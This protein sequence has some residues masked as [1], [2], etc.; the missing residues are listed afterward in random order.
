MQQW[1][2]RATLLI[3]LAVLCCGR[4]IDTEG[5]SLDAVEKVWR[6]VNDQGLVSILDDDSEVQAILR[7]SLA[8][9]AFERKLLCPGR[10][11]ADEDLKP[12][13]CSVATKDLS[14]HPPVATLKFR[15][16]GVPVETESIDEQVIRIDPSPCQGPSQA[17]VV[18]HYDRIAADS[19]TVKDTAVAIATG[20]HERC[21]DVQQEL[22]DVKKIHAAQTRVVEGLFV[23]AL[24]ELESG[25]LHIFEVLFNTSGEASEL[26]LP[27]SLHC[28]ELWRSTQSWETVKLLSDP[29]LT[30][31]GGGSL[32]QRISSTGGHISA[33]DALVPM[34][35]APEL[36]SLLQRSKDVALSNR[37]DY[38]PGQVYPKCFPSSIVTNQG[39]CGSCWAMAAVGAVGD[40]H[41][42]ANPSSMLEP[43]T[44]WRYT[45]S[46]QQVLSCHRVNGCAGGHAHWVYGPMQSGQLKLTYTK[47]YPYASRCF[48]TEGGVTQDWGSYSCYVFARLSDDN[49]Q[50]PCGCVDSSRRLVEQP[51]C[52]HDVVEGLGR[53]R[54]R[55][56]GRLPKPGQWKNLFQPENIWTNSEVVQLI[57]STLFQEGPVYASFDVY[58]D[59]GHF[60]RMTRGRSVYRHTSRS[61]D[62]EGGHAVV[63]VGWGSVDGAEYWSMR[64]S[65]GQDWGDKGHY[66][67]IRGINDCGVESDIVVPKVLKEN[68][69]HT[70]RLNNFSVKSFMKDDYLGFVRRPIWVLDVQCSN[71]CKPMFAVLPDIKVDNLSTWGGSKCCCDNFNY[72]RETQCAWVPKSQLAEGDW[73]KLTF[74]KQACGRYDLGRGAAQ[75][76]EGTASLCSSSLEHEATDGMQLKAENL[77]ST[78]IRVSIDL[79]LQ[80]Q[81]RGQSHELLLKAK[82]PGTD[83]VSQQ[84][85]SVVPKYS[86]NG[87]DHAARK[88]FKF[89][90]LSCDWDLVSEPIQ[91]KT[92]WGREWTTRSYY[93]LRI[94]AS[95][96]E[97]CHG[98]AIFEGLRDRSLHHPN[99][100]ALLSANEQ[101]S[102]DPR[103]K[104]WTAPLEE[105]PPGKTSLRVEVWPAGRQSKAKKSRTKTIE[106]PRAPGVSNQGSLWNP[107]ELSSGESELK[108]QTGG[109]FGM[110]VDNVQILRVA[111]SRPCQL[112]KF[113]FISDHPGWPVQRL[114]PPE[115][116]RIAVSITVGQDGGWSEA[117]AKATIDVKDEH[118]SVITRNVGFYL[119]K[120]GAIEI[121]QE[122]YRMD[123]MEA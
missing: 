28:E 36:Q 107:F 122:Q 80:P 73:L 39:S 114:N 62:K 115:R 103:V 97:D 12:D 47:R 22:T 106:F 78:R 74:G 88:L 26:V 86:A 34:H 11:V 19:K 17:E 59:F 6:K 52:K 94:T 49:P 5:Q 48:V 64:N 84:L 30:D 2:R 66:K 25:A 44:D 90:S 105:Y 95:C 91:V 81:L 9:I 119:A 27:S 87:K 123:G 113:R 63:M 43:G 69:Y 116:D 23:R 57:Q 110:R 33:L 72:Q 99:G 46:V 58:Q 93:V 92:L 3:L 70:L 98:A 50:K 38:H 35:S 8:A 89:D 54:I 42:I 7:A 109:F 117:W 24:T 4:R 71:P 76:E 101:P 14:S 82:I 51:E 53:F 83:I 102:E 111:C 65:W 1:L 85:Y 112:Q 68:V 118:N 31:P 41:C 121:G 55:S 18:D 61:G 40:R 56:Y 104:K 67:H 32:L 10:S 100:T 108:Q 45:L 96:S 60:V 15:L 29:G 21:P 75:T 77:D 120:S 37:S 13:C 79:G 20:L 16:N